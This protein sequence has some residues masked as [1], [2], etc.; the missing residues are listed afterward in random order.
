MCLPAPMSVVGYS[1]GLESFG[2]LG[3]DECPEGE[4]RDPDTGECV[5]ESLLD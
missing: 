3:D 1:N 5:P 4:G 2:N